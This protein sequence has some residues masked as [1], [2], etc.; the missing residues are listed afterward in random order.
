MSLRKS[1]RYTSETKMLLASS[2]ELHSLQ[3]SAVASHQT[4]VLATNLL[5]MPECIFL[6]M[7]SIIPQI[8]YSIRCIFRNFHAIFQLFF[9]RFR[10]SFE[11]E[12]QRSKMFHQTFVP[13]QIDRKKRYTLYWFNKAYY[14]TVTRFIST[15]FAAE[16]L[17][18]VEQYVAAGEPQA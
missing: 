18:M 5:E 2:P 1:A 15:G 3:C 17:K 7:A 4:A 9:V 11:C 8:G 16:W 13:M 14:N 12:K 10:I 6:A